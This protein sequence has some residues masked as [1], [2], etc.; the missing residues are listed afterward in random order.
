[1]K[2]LLAMAPAAALAACMT[3][4]PPPPAPYHAVGTE[5]FWNLLIDEH[6]LTFVEPDAQPVKQPTP[7]AIV[8]VAGEI[9]QTPRIDVNIVHAQCSDGMSDRVYPD[10]VQVTV[11]GRQFN[12]CG[13]EAVAPASL[14][15]TSWRVESVNESATP[16]GGNYFMNFDANRLGAKFGCNSMSGNY[17]QSANVLDLGAVI[18]TKM[19]C[20]DMRFENQ[21]GAILNEPMT[22]SWS[23]GDRLTLSNERGTIVLTRSY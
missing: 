5:P 23:G 12:G 22:M 11:D 16:K 8:G 15:G 19:A 7:R 18:S 14:A 20:S 10:K 4:P 1:M 3:I 2:A 9:Y 6:D 21:G 17:T 13:G